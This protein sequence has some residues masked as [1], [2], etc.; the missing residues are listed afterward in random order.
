M[1]KKEEEIENKV[2]PGFIYEKIWEIQKEK[3]GSK[4]Y[5]LRIA[6]MQSIDFLKKY[7]KKNDLI[8]YKC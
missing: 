2:Y 5:I 4:N 1:L 6:S 3:F 7:Y 8:N